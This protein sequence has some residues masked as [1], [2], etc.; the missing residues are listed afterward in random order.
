MTR[1]LEIDPTFEG[2]VGIYKDLN[3]A[4]RD[5]K[6]VPYKANF[7][8]RGTSFTH[9]PINGM[10]RA[11]GNPNVANKALKL[12][13]NSVVF[14]HT[15]TLDTAGEHKQNAPHLNQA[16]AVGC[17]FEHVDEY[18]KGSLTNYWRGIV[19]MELYKTNRFDFS[20]TSMR[21]MRNK[22]A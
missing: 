12:Y 14:G 3:L 4:A 9:I 7:N 15:H 18:A 11:I 20:T 13:H 10:G 19:E 8:L 6:W 16:L 5:F 22:Y 2:Q 21:Q 1:Y 17:Y